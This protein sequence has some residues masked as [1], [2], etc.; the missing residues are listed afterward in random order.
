MN[1]I[2]D[3]EFKE[4]TTLDEKSI[5][6]L[7]TETNQLYSQIETI[8]KVA[9]VMGVEAG[10]RL[11]VI[12]EKLPHG[13]WGNWIKENLS[14]SQRKANYLMK[15][16]DAA[17]DENSLLFS[18]SQ[19]LANVEISKVF[20]LL[21]AP[22]EV[23][24]E[25]IKD[26]EFEEKSLRELQSQIKLLKEELRAE[27]E[28]RVR[29]E[30]DYD[31]LLDENRQIKGQLNIL[32]KQTP[33]SRAIEQLEKEHQETINALAKENEDLLEELNKEIAKKSEALKKEKEKAKKAKE[34]LEKLKESAYKEAEEKVKAETKAEYD[35]I[36][37]SYKRKLEEANENAAKLKKQLDANSNQSLVAFK[38]NSSKLQEDF[39]ACVKL[40]DD[41]DDEM[42]TKMRGALKKVL[43]T[44]IG[45]L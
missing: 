12:K 36:E 18:N 37:A 38:L 27:S 8:G 26:P 7:A 44:M 23:Q 34:E 42:S 17:G 29:R 40:C 25:V 4:L 22:E 10:K 43:E 3:V 14:F 31:E 15:M 11:H 1:E 33:D 2:I 5:D 45:R 24:E 32:E 30:E 35:E 13:E 21:E 9:V 28:A 16:A 19:T 39:N 6:E 20:A 41:F